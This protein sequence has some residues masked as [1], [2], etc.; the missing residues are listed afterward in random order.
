MQTHGGPC[1]V[2]AVVQAQILKYLLFTDKNFDETSKADISNSKNGLKAPDKSACSSIKTKV[3][4]TDL[5]PAEKRGKM[6]KE[7]PLAEIETQPQSIKGTFSNY[8]QFW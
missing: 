1:G 2:L 5:A 7:S 6:S 4:S 8:Q 3:Q